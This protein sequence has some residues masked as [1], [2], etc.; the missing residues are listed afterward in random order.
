MSTHGQDITKLKQYIGTIV[1]VSESLYELHDISPQQMQTPE[2]GPNN[3]KVLWF[4]H[5][6]IPSLLSFPLSLMKPTG[7]HIIA[8]VR[9]L[10]SM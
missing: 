5:R 4:L 9:L 10:T 8:A 6:I 1:R 2:L 7:R 3:H